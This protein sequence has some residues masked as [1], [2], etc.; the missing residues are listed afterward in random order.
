MRTAFVLISTAVKAI[1]IVGGLVLVFYHLIK[2]FS[3]N[4]AGSKR[5]ALRYFIIIFLALIIFSAVEFALL[6]FL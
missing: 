6:A 2:G 5:K 1:I 4:D 3:N